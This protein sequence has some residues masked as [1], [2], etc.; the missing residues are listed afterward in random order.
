MLFIK[1]TT[2]NDPFLVHYHITESTYLCSDI[3]MHKYIYENKLLMILVERWFDEFRLFTR[4]V[5]KLLRQ[6]KLKGT[7]KIYKLDFTWL[8]TT[9]LFLSTCK[10]SIIWLHSTDRRTHKKCITWRY[11]EHSHKLRQQITMA[12][13][14][15]WQRQSFSMYTPCNQ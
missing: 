6:R 4:V 15:L 9:T 11:A 12:L 13:M 2:W 5:H 7:W 1:V 8:D 14:R 3:S 10:I